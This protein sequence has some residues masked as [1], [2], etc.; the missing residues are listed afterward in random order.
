MSMKVAVMSIPFRIIRTKQREYR[1][2]TLDDC[3]LQVRTYEQKLVHKD[4]TGDKKCMCG[5]IEDLGQLI[6][7]CMSWI[8]KPEPIH[9]FFMDNAGKHGTEIG[10]MEYVD[11][12]ELIYNVEVT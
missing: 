4:I 9:L 11:I 3:V 2:L 6:K 8:P 5:I 10:K 12:L 7:D 1:H